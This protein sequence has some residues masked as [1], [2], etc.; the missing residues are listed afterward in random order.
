MPYQGVVFVGPSSASVAAVAAEASTLLPA[1]TTAHD[2]LQVRVRFD[3]GFT[4]LIREV[5]ADERASI[6][7]DAN[8]SGELC[9][10]VPY[11]LASA[12]EIAAAGQDPARMHFEDY[13]AAVRAIEAAH[14]RASHWD[15]VVL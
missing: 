10:P 8:R 9:E 13:L 6:A 2:T 1:A 7:N 11:P 12:W 14:D 15:L 5:L 3:D 4:L